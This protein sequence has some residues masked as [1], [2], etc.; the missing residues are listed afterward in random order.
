[1]E[2]IFKRRSIR[3]YSG[4]EVEEE[5]IEEILKAAMAAP[6]A[7]GTEPWHFFVIRNKEIL[8]KLSELL[9]YGKMVNDCSFAILVCYD[10]ERNKLSDW[11][12]QD[13]SAACENIL[14]SCTY[15][16]LGAVW[17]GIYPREDRVDG[18]QN[19]L[20]IKDEF[21]PFALIPV[22]YPAEEKEAKD[23]IDNSKVGYID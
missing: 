16:D 20:G 13:L 5:K 15:L 8:K 22:G 17:L 10:L 1:M 11:F 12:Q 14:I 7:N 4:K 6:S 2:A 23:I 19:I 3:K 18:I 21:L 9:P